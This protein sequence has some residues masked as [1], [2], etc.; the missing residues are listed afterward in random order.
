MK[1]IGPV[2]KSFNGH[3]L[4]QTLVMP[5]EGILSRKS[6]ISMHDF[7]NICHSNDRRDDQTGLGL[8]RHF[9]SRT[10]VIS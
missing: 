9:I 7:I 4:V 6:V 1:D 3:K 10:V 5:A 8:L 2:I